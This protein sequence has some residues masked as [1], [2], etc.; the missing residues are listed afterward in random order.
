M[1]TNKTPP[2]TVRRKKVAA[3]PKLAGVVKAVAGHQVLGI[4]QQQTL[5]KYTGDSMLEYGSEVVE[6]RAIPDYRDG[7]KPV[8]R[9][10]VWAAYKMGNHNNKGFKKSARLVGETLGKFHPHGD[11]SIY[12]ALVG[13]AGTK[14]QGKEDGWA[15]RNISTP[16]FEGKGNWG[17]FVDSPA[18]SR[19]T[20]VRL[21]RFSDMFLLDQ[22]Y[23]AVMD[24]IPNYDES[25]QVPVILPAKV[26]VVL[27]NGFSSIAVGVAGA[28]PPFALK[29]VLT[30][31]R[32]ALSGDKITIKDCVKHLVP[33]YPYG[34]EC[35]SDDASM[36]E[37]MKGKGSASYIPAYEVNQKERTVT[38]TSVCPGLMS[39]RAI[40][41][42][43]EKLA[44]NKRVAHVDDDTDKKGVRYVVQAAR[45]VVGAALDALAEELVDIAVRS[46]SYFIGITMRQP[47][48]TAKF[49]SSNVVDIFTLWSAW[50]LEV[51]IKVLHRL[52]SIQNKKLER[53]Q[54]LLTA[55][56]NLD[57]IVKSLKLKT[58]DVDMKINGEIRSVDCST[59][60]LM[61]MLKITFEQ[62]NHIL[63]MRIRQLRSMERTTILAAIRVIETEIKAL[64]KY[65]KDPKVRILENL[66]EIEKLKL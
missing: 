30:L 56:D 62:A 48:G 41:T 8:H 27:L 54:L 33:D 46:E 21:S 13:M 25:E 5:A 55:V 34:G 1:A 42:F 40:Q 36:A 38:F 28:S 19:Y 31:T 52:I 63:D 26:P 49:K 35:I 45:G 43:L 7:L 6:Q 9:M 60:F 24:M 66:S 61:K 15:T 57:T 3:T 10:L 65:L 53:Q 4:R 64:N 47:D 37:V 50:R 14:F 18:A 20:E 23:L 22:D 58:A 51:E 2:P 16:L 39:P 29:G 11:M 59:A 17:D 32:K 44:A 12:N